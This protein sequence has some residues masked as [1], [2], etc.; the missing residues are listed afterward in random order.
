MIVKPP[1]ISF[2]ERLKNCANCRF[3]FDS[4]HS[5]DFF[6]DEPILEIACFERI[7][8]DYDSHNEFG[9]P[10]VFKKIADFA[11]CEHWE[12]RM[13]GNIHEGEK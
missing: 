7:R 1:E 4:D 6:T 13:I 12:M 8:A 9:L 11:P 5:V 2:D 3:I 10:F